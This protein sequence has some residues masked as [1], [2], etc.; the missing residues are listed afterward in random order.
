MAPENTKSPATPANGYLFRSPI[1][2]NARNSE[3]KVN[4][5]VMVP[6]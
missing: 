5:N 3:L 2:V 4:I 1:S 6:E